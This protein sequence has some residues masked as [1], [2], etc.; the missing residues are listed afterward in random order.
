MPPRDATA[1]RD[2]SPSLPT[3]GDLPFFPHRVGIDENLVQRGLARAHDS[4]LAS[5]GTLLNGKKCV[6]EGIIE[7]AWRDQRH[8][9]LPTVKPERQTTVG[10]IA[11][12]TDVAIGE[13]EG[14]CL[15]FS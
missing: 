11:Q 6:M 14:S 15:L 13:A 9:T 1:P 7:L 2:P 4:G 5:F 12:H 10:T 3:P 8:L